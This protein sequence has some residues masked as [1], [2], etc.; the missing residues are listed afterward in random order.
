MR[1]SRFLPSAASEKPDASCSARCASTRPRAPHSAAAAAAAA[2]RLNTWAREHRNFGV[3]RNKL[4]PSPSLHAI[5][6]RLTESAP[7]RLLVPRPAGISHRRTRRPLAHPDGAKGRAARPRSRAGYL[8]V[9]LRGDGAAVGGGELEGE[10][11]DEPQ[12][13]REMARELGAILLAGRAV[14][15]AA[16]AADPDVLGEVGDEGQAVEGPLIDGPDAVVDEV[17]GEEEREGEDGGV[18]LRLGVERPDALRVEEEEAGLAPVRASRGKHLAPDPDALGASVDSGP[19]AKTVWTA[20]EYPIKKE[21]LP[22][23]IQACH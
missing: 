18:V 8:E 20:N 4:S 16:A 14:A 9:L 6:C 19:D 21:A 1:R 10:V 17:G 3:R 2:G 15:A 7:P 11:A 5:F 23:A 22:C 13:G 12:E